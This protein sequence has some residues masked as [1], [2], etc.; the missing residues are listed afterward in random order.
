MKQIIVSISFP[1]RTYRLGSE[2]WH[3]CSR[4]ILFGSPPNVHI[5][6]L[7]LFLIPVPGDPMPS[8][9]LQ[10]YF[11]TESKLSLLCFKNS[12]I[13][14]LLEIR[15]NK[16]FEVLKDQAWSTLF[17][18]YPFLYQSI[19]VLGFLGNFVGCVLTWVFLSDTWLF[20]LKDCLIIH[21]CLLQNSNASILGPGKHN[22]CLFK[23]YRAF[24]YL[25]V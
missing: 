3:V 20:C 13:S 19:L 17:L 6:A 10:V 24:E 23:I 8:L 25:S 21:H 18:T 7:G 5:V 11:N 9:D 1:L 16:T 12:S 22:D 2:R 4:R 15:F 14:L